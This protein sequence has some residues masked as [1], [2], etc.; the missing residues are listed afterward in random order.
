[1]F[2]WIRKG[3]GTRA[4]FHFGWVYTFFVQL[5]SLRNWCTLTRAT[6][7]DLA[8]PRATVWIILQTSPFNYVA[9]YL[10][11]MAFLLTEM[12]F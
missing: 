9:S 5:S 1:M 2:A 8:P 10:F 7:C 12:C 11:R 4:E 6:S 3:C